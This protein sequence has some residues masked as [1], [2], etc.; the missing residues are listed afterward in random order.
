M[1]DR[2][3]SDSDTIMTH[4]GLPQ[5]A[6]PA[7]NIHGGTIL[8]HID[9]AGAVAAMRHARGRT[10]VTASIDRMEFKA[11]VH[12]GELMVLKASVNMVSNT[13]MEVGVRVEAENL[14]TGEVRHA[15][16]AY[17]TFV[18][19]DENRRPTAVPGLI[20]ETPEQHRRNREAL[21]RREVR[22]EERRREKLSQEG[23]TLARDEGVKELY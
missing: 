19:M 9:L 3:V 7:G 20:L 4:R 6:N 14:L 22:R 8:K 15:A 17:L 18:A 21:M 16:S 23:Q 2:K 11:A 12:V 1:N 5:D 10:V 13:S